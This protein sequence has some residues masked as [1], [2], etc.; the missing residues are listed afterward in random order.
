MSIVLTIG[1]AWL[2]LIAAVMVGWHR[3]MQNAQRPTVVPIELHRARSGNAPLI[4][5]Q[6][7][8]GPITRRTQ[9]H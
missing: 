5:Q 8:T 2:A 6:R 1:L 9:P 7:G 4:P 3:V